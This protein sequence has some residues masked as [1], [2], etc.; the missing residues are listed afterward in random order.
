[1][2]RTNSER[3]PGVPTARADFVRMAPSGDVARAVANGRV[4]TAAGARTGA[5]AATGRA[6]G[7]GSPAM[8]VRRLGALRR[9]VA[10]WSGDSRR[11]HW[12]IGNAFVTYDLDAAAASAAYQPDE[13]RIAVSAPRDIPQGTVLLRGARAITMRGTEIIE[14]ADVLVRNNRI[15][16]VGPRGEAPADARVI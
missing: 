8:P 5:A 1:M 11:V 14:N 15:V 16:S 12:S 10:W 6:R 4:Y 13:Q 7:P 9:G 3:E 2:P